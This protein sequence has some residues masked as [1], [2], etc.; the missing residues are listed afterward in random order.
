MMSRSQ[1]FATVALLILD[2]SWS[3]S[4]PRP[5]TAHHSCTSRH[6]YA[7]VAQVTDAKQNVQLFDFSYTPTKAWNSLLPLIPGERGVDVTVHWSSPQ[8]G[9]AMLLQRLFPSDSDIRERLQPVL[10]ES[11]DTYS[12]LLSC[13][14]T[15]KA[16]V[17]ATR[18]PSGTK[19]PR[20]HVDHV[21][22]RWVQ[23]LVGPGCDYVVGS[24]G[25]QWDAVNGIDISDT[26]QANLELVD[27]TVADVRHAQ[28]GQGVALWGA[29]NV[30]GRVPAVH[31]SPKLGPF[32]GRVLLTLDV[33]R[34][35][36]ARVT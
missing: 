22:M 13:Y 15:F 1:I 25:I 6:Y 31:K 30:D 28:P 11:M 32:E 23:S 3:F 29:E 18:G 36:W 9:S 10:Q 5:D 4:P 24:D 17:V 20:W 34:E 14:P 26:D 33:V 19:C 2:S 27:E 16:R 12:S 8:E 7:P 35:D 21:P